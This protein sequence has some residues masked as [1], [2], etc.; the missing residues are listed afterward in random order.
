M[1]SC[2]T[3]ML[4]C[5]LTIPI[6]YQTTVQLSLVHYY[7]LILFIR[8]TSPREEK[9]LIVTDYSGGHEETICTQ[10][11]YR[12]KIAAINQYNLTGE[13]SDLTEAKLVLEDCS[14][15]LHMM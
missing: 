15:E 13:F 1:Y 4:A 8:R 3:D 7:I 6:L 12:F 10:G 2:S 11:F 14:S 9:S 5:E